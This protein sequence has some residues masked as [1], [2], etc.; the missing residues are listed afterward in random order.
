VARQ[1]CSLLAIQEKRRKGEM[2]IPYHIIEDKCNNC[3]ACI[4]VLGCPAISVFN[5]KVAI[6]ADLCTGCSVCA[7]I[8]PYK[9]IELKR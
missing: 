3:L 2:M 9:A 6:D 5:Q 4:K 1:K 7:Q 8:C